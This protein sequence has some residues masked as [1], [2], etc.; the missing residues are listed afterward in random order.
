MQRLAKT[1]DVFEGCEDD[2]DSFV[3]DPLTRRQAASKLASVFDILGKLAPIMSGIKLDLRETFQRTESWDDF[4][5]ADLRQ[6][7]VK[8]F[9]IFEKLRGLK[10]QR[11]IMPL[12][13]VDSKLRVLT[14]VDAAKH[15]L[16]MGCWGGFKLKDGSW[17]NKLLLGRS[18]LAKSESIPKDE[19]EALCA[20][21]NM[22]WVVRIA[23]QEWVESSILFSDS[24]IALCW[25]TS[26]KLRL[27]LFHRNR[28]MQIRRVTELE[29]AY[30]IRT[31]NNPTDSGTRP[32]KDK[33]TD[34]GP[35][36]SWENG[37]SWMNYEIDEAVTHG[38]LKPTTTLRV[39]KLIE[40]DFNQGLLFGEKD[41]V[42]LE[43]LLQMLL[44]TLVSIVLR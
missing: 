27:S 36:S 21:S 22:A 1:V 17:S 37:D 4:M 24:M 39:S 3:P 25:L 16:M 23:L 35:E 8:N 32:D 13:A 29:S 20:G 18:L 43:S 30:H 38:I 31:E 28:V 9:L 44:S 41:S 42:S 33:I 11:A 26:E 6:K 34:V 7:W 14:G 19:L 5:P 10:F 15:G 2:L 40:D 12:D